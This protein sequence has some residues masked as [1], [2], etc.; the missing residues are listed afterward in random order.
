MLYP[1]KTIVI[2]GAPRSGTTLLLDIMASPLRYRNIFEPLIP[3]E[4]NPRRFRPAEVQSLF[5]DTTKMQKIGFKI[6]YSLRDIIRNQLNY[7]LKRENRL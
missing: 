1:S 4:F 7:F 5:S 6:N 3:V 2:A